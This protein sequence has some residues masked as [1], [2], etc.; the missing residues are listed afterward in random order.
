[1]LRSTFVLMILICICHGAS[2]TEKACLKKNKLINRLKKMNVTV[3]E[4]PRAPTNSIC[5]F[6][7]K[8]KD[9]CC[10]IGSLAAY[11]QRDGNN[12]KETVKNV[13]EMMYLISRDIRS[14]VRLASTFRS[15]NLTMSPLLATYEKYYWSEQMSSFRLIHDKIVNN[16]S[17]SVNASA[18]A[19][20]SHLAKIRSASLCSVCSGRSEKFFKE[21]K[22]MIKVSTCEVMMD[23]C[24]THFTD[25]VQFIQ[26]ANELINSI[27][28]DIISQRENFGP[29][30]IQVI[31]TVNKNLAGLNKHRMISLIKSYLNPSSASDKQNSLVK[32]CKNLQNLVMPT[33]IAKIRLPMNQLLESSGLVH[34]INT[35]F[36]QIF[37]QIKMKGILEKKTTH[38]LQ[39]FDKN[40]DPKRLELDELYKKHREMI[41]IAW[42]NYE[43]TI[44][45]TRKRRLEIF[46]NYEESD[47]V[48][49]LFEGDVYPVSSQTAFSNQDIISQ[50]SDSHDEHEPMYLDFPISFY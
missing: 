20:W 34:H 8:K 11:S 50:E 6:E 39:S 40:Q 22:A 30:A 35:I 16:F 15:N 29:R 7:W 13:T 19:C 14:T 17:E 3:F 45:R 41:K 10:E 25:L 33:F 23:K 46:S 4:S 31:H 48:E 38:S 27:H 49:I 9:S 5:E 36:L 37:I 47:L 21:D 28:N 44:R 2:C 12:I 42:E 18:N 26:N 43:E 32:I 1:M 24:E